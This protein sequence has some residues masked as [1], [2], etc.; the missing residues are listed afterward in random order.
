MRSLF[1]AKRAAVQFRRNAASQRHCAGSRRGR[2]F[3]GAVLWNIQRSAFNGMPGAAHGP[4]KPGQTPPALPK[5]APSP[6]PAAAS[7]IVTSWPSCARY[8]AV[9]TPTTPAPMTRTRISLPSEGARVIA[10]TDQQVLP[11]HEAGLV[12]A[13]PGEERA[14]LFRPAIAPGRRLGC[15]TRA[16]FLESPLARIDQPLNVVG[17]RLA[18]ENAGQD[19]VDGDAP[20]DGLAREAGDKPRQPRARAIRERKL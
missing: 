12:A 6:A 19:V 2:I 9:V 3:S 4:A 20:P 11:G 15:T 10:A 8:Q 1:S 18:V 17:L 5:V 14:E 16:D 13:E 7:T